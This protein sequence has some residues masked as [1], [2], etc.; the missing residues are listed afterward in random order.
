MASIS[1]DKNGNRT[2]QFVA[3]DRKR[4]SIRLGKMPVKGAN[5]IKA[6]VEA[7]NSAN[8]AGHAWDPKLAE[9]VAKLEEW[10]YDKL[11][12]VG[13]VPKRT[14]AEQATLAYFLDSYI[15]SR[16]DVKPATTI[17]Y[18]HTRRCLV[19][20]F[21]ANKPLEEITLAD[22]DDWRRWLA[23]N[24]GLAENTVR[25]RC[26]IARQFFRVAERRRLIVESPF[27]DLKGVSVKSNR[28]RD[29]FVTR[30]E[31]AKVLDACP[32]NEWRLIFAL[33]RYGGLR[34]PSEHLV[35]TW[36]DVDWDNSRITIRSPKTEHHDGQGI[37]VIPLF[38]ELR[39]YLDEAFFD[40]EES[41]F[42]N[43][44][45]SRFQHESAKPVAR[46]HRRGRRETMAK[47]IPELAGQP[48]D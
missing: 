37:R 42:V 13:L 24:Q 2:I 20:Y 38:P 5:T 9:W 14:A 27:A 11:A 48:S 26:G 7:L 32:D 31:A 6:H 15:A 8:I 25:R 16:G 17:V 10:L 23:S 44:T 33:S 19:E 3:G 28:S 18:G 36:R 41:D 40:P 12:R 22:A 35:L 46:Y 29:Y 1:K 34:C 43:S 45:L 30:A 21:G 39:P 4:R 47:V